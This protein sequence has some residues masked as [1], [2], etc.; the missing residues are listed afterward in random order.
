M[1]NLILVILAVILPV[2][3]IA[4]SY[5]GW[6]KYIAL[7]KSQFKYN[8]KWWRV[9]LWMG[10]YGISVGGEIGFYNRTSKHEPKWF[11]CSSKKYYMSFTLYEYQGDIS[12]SAN[13]FNYSTFLFSMKKQKHWWLTG[14]L[15]N[16]DLLRHPP[17]TKNLLMNGSIWFD[18]PEMAKLFEENL[19]CTGLTNTDYATRRNKNKV[20][21]YWS[22]R[23]V[24]RTLVKYLGNGWN[25]PNT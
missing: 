5:T 6:S 20:E 22:P 14:F 10:R 24:S 1:K 3:T 16:V 7:Q 15:Y 12:A 23:F 11:K 18:T 17:Y 9:E 2:N 19:E 13:P 4:Q 25:G 8:N 21:I